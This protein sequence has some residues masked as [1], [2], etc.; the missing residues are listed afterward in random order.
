MDLKVMNY[1]VGPWGNALMMFD[2]VIDEALVLRGLALKEKKDGSGNYVQFPSKARTKSKEGDTLTFEKGDDGYTIY[3][4]I[5]D[6]YFVKEGESR[7]ATEAAW[8]AKA[9]ITEAAEAVYAKA[10]TSGDGRGASG[11]S[12]AK[13]GAAK[14]APKKAATAKSAASK[15]GTQPNV[16]G[17]DGDGEDDDLPF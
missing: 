1:R 6:L 17:S 7:K 14:A 2:L 15:S 5:V 4:Q 16:E 12:G 9:E 3:D 10:K 13:G 11:K 8:A